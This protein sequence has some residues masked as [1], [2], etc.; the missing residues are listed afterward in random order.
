VIFGISLIPQFCLFLRHQTMDK[1][2]KHNSFNTNTPSSESY[3]DYLNLCSSLSVTDR[4]QRHIYQRRKYSLICLIFRV[5]PVWSLIPREESGLRMT[6]EHSKELCN[7][8]ASLHIISVIKS[9]MRWVGHVARMGAMR[10]AYNILVRK[11]EGK[12]PLGRCRH[13]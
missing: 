4:F 11:S 2:Q 8:Y 10:N 9:R 3:R 1:V 7:L 5:S 12:R 13:E 6:S